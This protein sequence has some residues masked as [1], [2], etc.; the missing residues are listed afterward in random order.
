MKVLMVMRTYFIF[1]VSILTVGLMGIGCN[2]STGTDDFFGPSSICSSYSQE[3]VACGDYETYSNAETDCMERAGDAICGQQYREYVI[4]D[5]LYSGCSNIQ[6]NDQRDAYDACIQD[7]L[8][9]SDVM[10]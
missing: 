4:C 10:R 2:Y 1:I 9:T 5:H 7:K 8:R 6:C 3:G